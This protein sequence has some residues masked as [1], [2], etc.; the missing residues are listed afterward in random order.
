MQHAAHIRQLI[1]RVDNERKEIEALIPVVRGE[2]KRQGL[3]EAHK[4]IRETMQHLIKS[5]G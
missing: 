3:L 5:A 4:R 2:L 1:R